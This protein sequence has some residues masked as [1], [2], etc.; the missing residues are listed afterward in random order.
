MGHSAQ[1]NFL[2]QIPTLGGL[3]W[4]WMRIRLFCRTL[5]LSKELFSYLTLPTDNTKQRIVGL[6]IYLRARHVVRWRACL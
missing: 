2:S 1:L 4:K 5:N 6:G 3:T